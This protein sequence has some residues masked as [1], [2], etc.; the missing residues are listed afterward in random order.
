MS[1]EIPDEDDGHEAG[2]GGED[3]QRDLADGRLV[4]AAQHLAVIGGETVLGSGHGVL[5]PAR[6]GR[7]LLPQ[8]GYGWHFTLT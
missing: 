4:E 8:P 1:P 6:L 3:A 7:S 5:A 2:E